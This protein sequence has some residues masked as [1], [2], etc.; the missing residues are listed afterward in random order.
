MRIWIIQA[1]E[2]PADSQYINRRL[3]RSNTLCEYLADS[4]HTVFRWRS[5]F[6]H[7]SKK[8]LAYSSSTIPYD[9]YFQIL[10]FPLTKSMLES[11]E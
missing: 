7:Q 9:N 2:N 1:Q 8:F 11:H 4:G 3:W 10:L 5:A 6:S